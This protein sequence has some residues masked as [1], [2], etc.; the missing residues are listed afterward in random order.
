MCYLGTEKAVFV[1]YG[2]FRGA[3]ETGPN[4]VWNVT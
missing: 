1:S 2:M 3:E 4:S